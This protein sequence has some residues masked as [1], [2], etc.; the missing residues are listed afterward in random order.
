MIARLPRRPAA[1]G[2]AGVREE[3]SLAALG[4]SG[5]PAAARPEACKHWR[6]WRHE[7]S[8]RGWSPCHPAG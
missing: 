1:P 7:G 4:A 6:R 3:G 5:W 8:V 2:N